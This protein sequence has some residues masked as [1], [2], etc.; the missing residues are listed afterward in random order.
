LKT[1][2]ER[3]TSALSKAEIERL[4]ELERSQEEKTRLQNVIENLQDANKIL[5]L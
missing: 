2:N 4:H 3:L 5:L 1:E